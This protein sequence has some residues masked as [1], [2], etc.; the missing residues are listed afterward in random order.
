MWYALCQCQNYFS[1]HFFVQELLSHL[2]GL[3]YIWPTISILAFDRL[4]IPFLNTATFFYWFCFSSNRNNWPFWLTW[5]N[6]SKH[7]Q[8]SEYFKSAFKQFRKFHKSSLHQITFVKQIQIR[9][10]VNEKNTENTQ[11]RK[12]NTQPKKTEQQLN[13]SKTHLFWWYFRI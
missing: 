4:R 2:L 5:L 1:T 6:K 13:K 3:R 9:S 8:V 11:Q 12:K 10:I 7:K